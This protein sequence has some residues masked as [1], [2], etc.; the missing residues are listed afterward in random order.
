[1]KEE[2][3][4]LNQRYDLRVSRKLGLNDNIYINSAYKKIFA[5]IES[6]PIALWNHIYTRG[7]KTSLVT[8]AYRKL[9]LAI[10]AINP[11]LIEE[12][13]RKK[14]SHNARKKLNKEINM[15]ILGTPQSHFHKKRT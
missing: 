13:T 10:E 4:F 14:N 6:D 15:G 11:K 3:E 2:K 1:M 12:N 8:T 9:K 5:I 7:N